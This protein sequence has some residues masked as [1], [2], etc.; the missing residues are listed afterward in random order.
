MTMKKYRPT[1]VVAAS[2]M[3]V[4][5]ATPLKAAFFFEGL[6]PYSMRHCKEAPVD[7]LV[8]QGVS[9]PVVLHP[10]EREDAHRKAER[11]F[12]KPCPSQPLQAP[13]KLYP[14]PPK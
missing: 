9:D 2:L 3:I 13:S 11:D 12:R 5:L 4:A 8:Q 10:S 1:G 6:E 7:E 14:L